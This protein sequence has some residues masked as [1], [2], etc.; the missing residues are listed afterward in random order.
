MQVGGGFGQWRQ[1]GEQIAALRGELTEVRGEVAQLKVQPQQ[2]QDLEPIKAALAREAR[3]R[4]AAFTTLDAE[5]RKEKT[6]RGELEQKLQSLSTERTPKQLSS[7]SQNGSDK[8]LEPIQALV[9][10]L[11][12]DLAAEASLREKETLELRE[13]LEGVGEH[14]DQMH[15]AL[16]ETVKTC[17]AEERKDHDRSGGGLP[18]PS[19]DHFSAGDTSRSWPRDQQG[20]MQER[21][22][23][24]EKA[25]EDASEKH[26]QELDALETK[27]KIEHGSLMD[28]EL[29]KRMDRIE[30]TLADKG[31]HL[32]AS[33]TPGRDNNARD[34]Q[35]DLLQERLDQFKKQ[36]QGIGEMHTQDFST[37]VKGRS[38]DQTSVKD[39][40]R[41]FET[42][43]SETTSKL[44]N[45]LSDFETK[46]SQ[47]S[48]MMI[49]KEKDAREANFALLQERS[50]QFK[51]QLQE[52]GESHT[53]DLASNQ[54]SVNDR[55]KRLESAYSE[56]ATMHAQEL[57]TKLAAEAATRNTDVSSIKQRMDAMDK[58]LKDTGNRQTDQLDAV[59]QKMHG[60]LQSLSES[61]GTH[62]QLLQDH[63]ESHSKAHTRLRDDLHRLI[64]DEREAHETHQA[65]LKDHHANEKDI[66]SKQDKHIQDKFD[67]LEQTH[68]TKV[69]AVRDEVLK[70]H[71]DHQGAVK[72]WA[73]YLEQQV[74]THASQHAEHQQASHARIDG[75]QHARS[76]LGSSL[77]D[78]LDS[79]EMSFKESSEAQSQGLESLLQ[80]SM[81]QM[82]EAY[83]TDIAGGISS[84]RNEILAFVGNEKDA[85][86]EQFTNLKDH[87]EREQE[88]HASRHGAV[89]ASLLALEKKQL[90][91]VA[92]LNEQVSGEGHAR[93]FDSVQEHLASEKKAREA[94]ERLSQNQMAD[95]A[96][97]RETHERSVQEHL[98]LEKNG[99]ETHQEQLQTMLA[100]ETGQVHELLAQERELFQQAMGKERAAFQQATQ[101]ERAKHHATVTA[102]VDSLQRTVD[103]FDS[104]VRKEISERSEESKR[105]R[106]SVEHLVREMTGLRAQTQANGLASSFVKPIGAD[107]CLALLSRGSYIAG[108]GSAAVRSDAPY[109]PSRALLSEPSRA[110]S[111][112][113]P[114]GP[115]VLNLAT[116]P[117]ESKSSGSLPSAPDRPV[118]ASKKPLQ[119]V[120]TVV[121]HVPSAIPAGVGIASPT[122]VACPE[123]GID[124]PVTVAERFA[125]E[126]VSSGP[127]LG[128]A[129]LASASSVTRMSSSA[130]S[131]TPQRRVG[132]VASLQKNIAGGSSCASP[133]TDSRLLS[134]SFTTDSYSISGSPSPGLQVRNT[135]AATFE[136]EDF[137]IQSEVRTS[138]STSE[139]FE[140]QLAN[141]GAGLVHPDATTVNSKKTTSLDEL[142]RRLGYGPPPPPP[143]LL[144]DSA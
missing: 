71:D 109:V 72:N 115:S 5:L 76:A 10:K 81:R 49:E 121:Q 13:E 48:E 88:T 82:A 15:K 104:L 62:A 17:L 120:S 2:S 105:V 122:P 137:G 140:G 77:M 85:R 139:A 114:E 84:L 91:D 52:M 38:E 75:E 80:N 35:F 3:D 113:P 83:K 61:H 124:V 127:C 22:K 45:T 60:D 134:M 63:K 42:T 130:S 25:M 18:R 112:E 56:M 87:L 138:A 100:Q 123:R 64:E 101:G 126:S 90:D 39:K 20:P 4:G 103:I 107:D 110:S 28:P 106:Q 94:H 92:I 117:W 74:H 141:P 86:H 73:S 14:K 7:R 51:K 9:E 24:L 54:T 11:K 68:G 31:V 26:Q 125:S 129:G 40:L 98:S 79:L 116:C 111:V 30:N 108:S 144:M 27:F 55:F 58:L 23:S 133:A 6:A 102:R 142:G 47:T 95:D 118:V 59:V 12:G 46:F 65:W 131:V 143:A 36:L 135:I 32:D 43:L 16:R 136:G 97:R 1:L 119:I 34:P 50:D 29:T 132:D 33:H 99:R 89:H 69:A 21:L 96:R 44:E 93:F 19:D 128:V 57:D 37:L 8:H 78:R 41:R 66:R 67:S 53:Q 70:A